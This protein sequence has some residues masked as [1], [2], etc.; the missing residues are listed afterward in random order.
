MKTRLRAAALIFA[1]LCLFGFLY[2]RTN[3]VSPDEHY[4]YT[5]ALQR[6]R[7][8]DTALNANI[9]RARHREL[10]NYDPLVENVVELKAELQKVQRPAG[11]L[12]PVGRGRIRSLLLRSEALLA[13]KE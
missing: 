7:R 12:G 8:L 3:A 11:F 9:L 10:S 2:F 5:H 1:D 4:A 6:L 13:R